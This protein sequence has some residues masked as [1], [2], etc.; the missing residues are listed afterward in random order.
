[1]TASKEDTAAILTD[2]PRG[3]WRRYP[4]TG[5]IFVGTA[6]SVLTFG[7]A[8]FA[9]AP[10]TTAFARFNYRHEAQSKGI[11]MTKVAF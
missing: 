6:V 8:F 1:L 9:G 7:N 2:R 10:S 5:N 4:A 3:G 11:A